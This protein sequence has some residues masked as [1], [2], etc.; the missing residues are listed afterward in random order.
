MRA[1]RALHARGN[2]AVTFSFSPCNCLWTAFVSPLGSWKTTLS[3]FDPSLF[4]QNPSASSSFSYNMLSPTPSMHR[5]PSVPCS[6][7]FPKSIGERDAEHNTMLMI[8]LNEKSS[9]QVVRIYVNHD[10]RIWQIR[11][12]DTCKLQNNVYY[13]MQSFKTTLFRLNLMVCVTLW[14]RARFYILQYGMTH[15]VCRG[16]GSHSILQ[17]TIFFRLN[18][19]SR[20]THPLPTRSPN[21]AQAL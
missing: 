15:G 21:L 12:V 16:Q 2:H 14:V 20:S 9:A 17:N 13:T 19:S 4:S 3:S 6:D 8:A 10:Q 1:H 7:A 18:T 11:Q 5:A